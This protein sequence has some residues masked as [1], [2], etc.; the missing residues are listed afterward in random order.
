MR[1]H[2]ILCTIRWR[3]NL[4]YITLNSSVVDTMIDMASKNYPELS[5]E[6]ARLDKLAALT[7]LASSD[8]GD[9]LIQLSVD[10]VQLFVNK[11]VDASE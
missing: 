7:T 3:W 9:Q 4:T 2:R 10:D 11:G 5:P 6:R 1:C 8:A